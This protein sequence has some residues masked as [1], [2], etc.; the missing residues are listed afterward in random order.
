MESEEELAGISRRDRRAAKREQQKWDEKKDSSAE[1][2]DEEGEASEEEKVFS[3]DEVQA[4]PSKYPRRRGRPP[5]VPREIEPEDDAELVKKYK[6]TPVVS[7][8]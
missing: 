7:R 2:D 5:K 8:S 1:E 3:E 6:F 4:Q